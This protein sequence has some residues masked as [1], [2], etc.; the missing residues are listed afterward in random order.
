MVQLSIVDFDDQMLSCSESSLHV[1]AC[2]TVV[3]HHHHHHGLHDYTPSHKLEFMM[4]DEP[5][6][7][8]VLCADEMRGTAQHC[9]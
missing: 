7:D 5:A 6:Q 1:V 9:I 3:Q 8:L 2:T 4:V